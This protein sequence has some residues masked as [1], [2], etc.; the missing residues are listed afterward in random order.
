[1]RSAWPPIL[2]RPGMFPIQ[3]PLRKVFTVRRLVRPDLPGKWVVFD[4]VLGS[5]VAAGMEGREA[6]DRE[7]SLLNKREWLLPCKAD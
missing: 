6:A 5:P 1:M 7:R 2:R 4:A 3:P